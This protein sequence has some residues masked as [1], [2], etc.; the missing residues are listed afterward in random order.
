[1]QV[2]WDQVAAEKLKSSHTVLELETFEVNGN[3]LTAYCVVPAEKLFSELHQL[4]NLVQ[5]H[6]GFIKSFNEKNYQLC[7]DIAPQ[8]IGRFGGELDSFY[9]AILNKIKTPPI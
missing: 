2:I 3:L 1:M 7:Q 4:E 6:A 9:E 5:L 8:L